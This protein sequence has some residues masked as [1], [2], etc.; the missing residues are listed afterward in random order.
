MTDCFQHVTGNTSNKRKRWIKGAKHVFADAMLKA[1]GPSLKP[2]NAV[3]DT[4]PRF[5]LTV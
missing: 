1:P 2:Q 3:A 4:P 5:T